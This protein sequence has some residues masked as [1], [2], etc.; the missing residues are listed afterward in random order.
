[1]VALLVTSR[2]LTPAE[3]GAAAL[4]YT[5]TAFGGAL[6]AQGFGSPIVRKRVLGARDVATAH[7]LSVVT[8][9]LIAVAVWFGA[10]LVAG[11]LSGATISA[12]Q[13]GGL[14]F[15]L[16]AF[17]S[18]ALALRQRELDFKFISKV[19]GFASAVGATTSIALAAIGLG[20]NAL[21]AGPLAVYAVTSLAML[22]SRPPVWGATSRASAREILSFGSPVAGSGF[23]YIATRNVNY[24][25]LAI[26][27][28]A[29]QVGLYFRAFQLGV[30]YQTK[31]GTV[32]LKLSLPLLAKADGP[33]QLRS[34]RRRMTRLNTVLM[35]PALTALA[36]LAPL[37]VPLA[38][39]EAWAE[40]AP[41]TQV[42]TVVGATTVVATGT[43]ALL[44]AAGHPRVM[45]AFYL[46]EFCAYASSVWFLSEY[47][48]EAV[49]IGSAVVSVVLLIILQRFV[50]QPYVGI[51]AKETLYH[52]L[53]PPVVSCIP[54]AVICFS[55]TALA[56]A[57]AP[58][59]LVVALAGG[60][61]LGAY[62]VVLRS[63]FPGEWRDLTALVR[64]I[65]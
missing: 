45:L 39:G 52:D 53:V 21:I 41:L 2:L 61:G 47:S 20:T 49:C 40:A 7:L 22:A 38:F 18:V 13:L 51:P 14:S 59:I 9:A 65:G 4:G 50:V 37:L 19:D 36:G 30:E 63:W 24:A 29:A 35:F 56:P 28:P 16:T 1:M 33:E 3:V 12:I 10:P 54:L 58:A 34:M 26:K 27:L 46:L 8:G 23:L 44:I 15:V 43:N 31:V 25:V 62:L 5:V 42:L 11:P 6:T 32:L 64:R 17:G 57:G 48:L 55:A 60:L